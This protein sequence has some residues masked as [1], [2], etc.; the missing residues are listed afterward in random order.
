MS[1]FEI[2]ALALAAALTENLLLG[3]VLGA[4]ALVR[5]KGSLS[6]CA[7]AGIPVPVLMAVAAPVCWCADFF[8][9]RPLG[10]EYLR[11]VVFLPCARCWSWFCP[12]W[13]PAFPAW[14][15]R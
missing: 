1:I 6:Q 8:L 2:I 4:G 3:R 9:L 10:L 14:A 5:Q 11:L 13:R 12:P 7:I 15:K